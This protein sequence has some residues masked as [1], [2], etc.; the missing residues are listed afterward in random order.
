LGAVAAAVALI[1]FHETVR[2]YGKALIDL[3]RTTDDAVPH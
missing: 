3:D 2:K 1:E